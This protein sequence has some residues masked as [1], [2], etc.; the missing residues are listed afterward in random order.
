MP[1]VGCG[2]ADITPE[3]GLPMVGMPGSPRGEGTQWPLRSRVFLVDSGERRIAVICLDL[4][5]LV[6]QHVA[7]LR[8]RLAA[9]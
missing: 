9:L 6:S 8:Q 3:P 1:R 5:A 4:I 7:E 2:R